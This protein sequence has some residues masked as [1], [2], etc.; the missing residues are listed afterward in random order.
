MKFL[1]PPVNTKYYHADTEG[2]LKQGGL[3]SL[4]GVHPTPI[5]HGIIAYEFLKAM[6]AAGVTDANGNTVNTDLTWLG[7]KGILQSD[8]LYTN[9]LKNMQEIYGKDEIAKLGLRLID[10]IKHFSTK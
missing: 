1:Y 8:L 10:F 7:D 3:F 5:G 4:D 2:K 6:E 9:P